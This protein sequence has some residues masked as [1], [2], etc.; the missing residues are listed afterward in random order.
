MLLSNLYKKDIN[1]KPKREISNY[2]SVIGLGRELRENKLSN[3]RIR[4]ITSLLY[5]FNIIVPSKI[6]K[7]KIN[8]KI[9]NLFLRI[10][11]HKEY[12]TNNELLKSVY[13]FFLEIIESEYKN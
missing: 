2:L 9:N 8:N 11:S 12:Y 10:N 7:E 3:A 5:I 6:V 13:S 1:I 4:Q